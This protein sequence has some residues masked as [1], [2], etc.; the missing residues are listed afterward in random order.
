MTLLRGHRHL[1]CRRASLHVHA[2]GTVFPR[3]LW[4][5]TEASAQSSGLTVEI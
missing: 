3:P 5:L 2:T 1:A 4:L